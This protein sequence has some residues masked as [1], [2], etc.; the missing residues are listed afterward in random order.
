[1]PGEQFSHVFYEVLVHPHVYDFL[2]ELA[3]LVLGLKQLL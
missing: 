2:F 3:Q 1:M